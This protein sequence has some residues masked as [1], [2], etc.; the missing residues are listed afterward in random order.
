MGETDYTPCPGTSPGAAA[1]QD[2]LNVIGRRY[3]F[4][5]LT[6]F[7]AAVQ[8]QLAVRTIVAAIEA[9]CV[10]TDIDEVIIARGGGS[11]ESASLEMA[12]A[13]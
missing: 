11:K 2:I 8:G 5:K 3:P 10:R 1:L 12:A 4:V 9:V 7:P 6:L 13:A